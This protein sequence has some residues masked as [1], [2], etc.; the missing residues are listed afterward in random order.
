MSGVAN[1]LSLD[2]RSGWLTGVPKQPGSLR[3]N[4]KV[5]GKDGPISYAVRVDSL[6]EN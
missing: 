6:P 2:P 1:G 3:L 5:E 4:L